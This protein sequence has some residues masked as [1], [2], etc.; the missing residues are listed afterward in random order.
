[1]PI[2]AITSEQAWAWIG[3]PLLI[4]FARAADVTV[5][6]LRIVLISRGRRFLA[7]FLGFFELMIWL[8]AIG[9]V[10]K[11]LDDSPLLYYVAY[12]AGFSLG[13]YVG[14]RIEEKIAIG[15]EILRVITR[16]PAT[17]LLNELRQ[18][19]LGVTEVPG[20]GATGPVSILFMVLRRRDLTDVLEVVNRHHPRAF[21][22]VEDVRQVSEGVFPRPAA[23]PLGIGR[24]LRKGK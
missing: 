4:F 19:G 20:R 23:L 8:L 6:T 5:G 16:R 1:M 15:L 17:E 22:S 13:N 10:F 21:Y 11:N 7:P 2:L 12:A 24:R 3:L 14:M 18:R 9:Q